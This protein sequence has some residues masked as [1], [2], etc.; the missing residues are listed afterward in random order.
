M[1]CFLSLQMMIAEISDINQ[2]LH[3]IISFTPGREHTGEYLFDFE[4]YLIIQSLFWWKVWWEHGV[5]KTCDEI[6]LMTCLNT[7]LWMKML[8]YPIWFEWDCKSLV[9][10][11]SALAQVVAWHS[12]CAKLL[13]E[14][15]MTQIY[16]A[17]SWYG[18]ANWLNLNSLWPSFAIGWYL[19]WGLPKLCSLISP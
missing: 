1:L 14:P 16:V 15:M 9:E 13:P 5:N 6:L 17:V 4:K 10:D 19:G 7:F 3:L 18:I 11:K 12:L 2:N 8:K